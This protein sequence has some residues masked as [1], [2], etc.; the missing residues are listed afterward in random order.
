MTETPAL[1]LIGSLRLQIE[2]SGSAKIVKSETIFQLAEKMELASGLRQ[3]PGTVG[4]QIFSR[5][6]QAKMSQKKTKR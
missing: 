6:I 4:F 1:R 5:G 3:W 2:N